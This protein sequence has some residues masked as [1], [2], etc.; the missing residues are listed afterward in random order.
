MCNEHHNI[1]VEILDASIDIMSVYQEFIKKINPR[2][3]GLLIGYVDHY[4]KSKPVQ[5]L[6]YDMHVSMAEKTLLKICQQA[7][8]RFS[9]DFPIYAAHTKGYIPAG[10]L[11]TLVQASANNFKNAND[12]CAYVGDEIRKRLPIWK[13]EHYSDGTSDWLPGEF[14]LKKAAK[15]ATAIS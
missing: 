5:G 2:A 9:K 7:Q 4:N 6:T 1:Y 3:V 13:L 12:I 10:G 8:H 11:C 14:Q 15:T